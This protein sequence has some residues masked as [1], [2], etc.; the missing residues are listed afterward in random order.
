MYA[1]ADSRWWTYSHYDE[2]ALAG[3]WNMSP[4][5][6]EYHMPGGRTVTHVEAAPPHGP[7]YNIVC[8]DGHV[9][10]VKRSDYLFPPRTARNWN[11]DN[12]PHQEAWAPTSDWVVQQ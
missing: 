1:V 9:S 7:G 2:R 12:Q 10:L 3:N 6:Y 11:R 8:C 4:W 5:K